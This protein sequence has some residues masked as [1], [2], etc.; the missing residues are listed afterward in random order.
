[1][2][3]YCDITIKNHKRYNRKIVFVIFKDC[4]IDDSSKLEEV[5]AAYHKVIQQHPGIS[6]VIDTRGVQ[7]C[8]KTMAF[9]QAHGM[10]KYEKVVRSNL[11]CLSIIMDNMLLEN[12]LA[13]ITSVQPFVI[14]TKV[15]KDNKGALYFLTEN[16]I[17]ASE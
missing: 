2:P 5:V 1:M 14:P 4:Y 7:G 10:K 6:S 8:K 11:L 15:V 13:T 9:S 12:L 3:E 17:K 16:F